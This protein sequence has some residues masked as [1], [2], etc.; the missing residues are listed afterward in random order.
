MADPIFSPDGQFMWDGSQWIPAPP[1]SQPQATHGLGTNLHDSVMQATGDIIQGT[2]T[3][4]DRVVIN[5]TAAQ[6]IQPTAHATPVTSSTEQC[7]NCLQPIT[8]QNTRLKCQGFDHKNQTTC[9]ETFCSSCELWWTRMARPPNIAPLCQVH[10]KGKKLQLDNK[11]PKVSVI[12]QSKRAIILLSEDGNTSIHFK[13][14]YHPYLGFF[15]IRIGD[16]T[17]RI[18]QTRKNTMKMGG[19][20]RCRFMFEDVV[21]KHPHNDYSVDCWVDAGLWTGSAHLHS[22]K[23]TYKGHLIFYELF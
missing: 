15:K 14:S 22:L 11:L 9:K 21:C 1:A 8:L 19:N 12:S 16:Q 5:Q 7:S 23:I 13:I 18:F 20:P 3:R 17:K 2:S 4:I 6:P 10:F